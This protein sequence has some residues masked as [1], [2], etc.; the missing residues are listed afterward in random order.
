M[1]KIILLSIILFSCIH[2]VFPQVEF[3]NFSVN[4]ESDIVF[5]VRTKN[6]SGEFYE[7]TFLKRAAT[8]SFEQLTFYPEVLSV[9]ADGQILQVSNSSGTISINLNDAEKNAF[10]NFSVFEQTKFQ[11]DRASLQVSPSGRYISMVEAT[12]FV[13]GNLILYDSK[14]NK[15]FFIT[16][17][18]LQDAKAI[19]W[20]PDESSFLFEKNNEIFFTRPTWL[21]QSDNKSDYTTRFT[22]TKIANTSLCAVK[23]IDKSNFYLVENSYLYR[24]NANEVLTF[25]LYDS[26]LTVKNRIAHVVFPFSPQND[27]IYFSPDNT[28]LLFLKDTN[29]LY[30]WKLQQNNSRAYGTAGI[31]YLPLPNDIRSLNV[32]WNDEIP[33][34]SYQTYSDSENSE[35]WQVTGS[36]F[37]KVPKKQKVLSGSPNGTYLLLQD[38][39]LK[40]VYVK[41]GYTDKTI[42]TFNNTKV[43]SHCWI[44]NE[45][46]VLGTDSF[47][48]KLNVIK[49]SQEILA[50]SQIS[51]FAWSQDETVILAQSKNMSYIVKNAGGFQWLAANEQNM[52]AKKTYNQ[53]YRLYVDKAGGAFK[54]MIFFRSVKDLKTFPLVKNYEDS[55]WDVFYTKQTAK[56]VALIFDIMENGDGL[57][58][59]LLNLKKHNI[60]ASFFLTGAFIGSEPNRVRHIVDSGFQC[61]S[62]FLSSLNISDSR[63]NINKEFITGGLGN[64]EDAFY[65]TTGKELSLFWHT[66]Y[67]IVNDEIIN[68]AREAGYT[69]VLPTITI[70]DWTSTAN[71]ATIPNA[72]QNS[73]AIINYIMKNI[74]DAAI[75]PIQ[76]DSIAG[77]NDYLYDNIDL[78]IRLL[79]KHGYRIIDLQEVIS[80]N[81]KR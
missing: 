78:L 62:L 58:K 15:K 69:F 33:S 42:F 25:A 68:C 22:A 64:V 72:P 8:D 37:V 24:V 29:K 2:F 45:K 73:Y 55:S 75:I 13:F 35:L 59:V 27:T 23:W 21:L 48:L 63:Y 79:K 32:F 7:T 65:R 61:A 47:L 26:I 40:K 38:E 71:A 1:R 36:A 10:N 76:L 80:K 17:E 67:Y 81:M 46:L 28:A 12:D 31:P 18:I 52:P 16:D 5:S 49:R 43:I 44:D 3:T 74:G 56:R 19:L 6:D 51:N 53:Q 54:N 14:L 60:P 77:R 34:I 20:S 57:E 41:N 66:A 9:D 30:F 50:L 4:A 11:N 39:T 70:A